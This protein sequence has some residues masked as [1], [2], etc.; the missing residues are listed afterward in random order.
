M[1]NNRVYLEE[2]YRRLEQHRFAVIVADRQND[3]IKSGKEPFSEENNVWVERVTRPLLQ[4]YQPL[5][6]FPLTGTQL[7]VPKP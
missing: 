5:V 4:Y 6:T 7:L 2:F 1:S 3:L